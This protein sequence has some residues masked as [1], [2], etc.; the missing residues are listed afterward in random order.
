MTDT[1][2]VELSPLLKQIVKKQ[3]GDVREALRR[4]KDQM[5]EQMEQGVTNP[6]LS[7]D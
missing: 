2:L 1:A 6:V 7:L 4:L 3:V 5:I